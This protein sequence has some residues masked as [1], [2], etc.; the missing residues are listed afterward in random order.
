M[1]KTGKNN[2]MMVEKAGSGRQRSTFMKHA[3]KKND[4]IRNGR[5]VFQ[6]L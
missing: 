6:I 1:Q 5:S 4:K 2:P 3:G